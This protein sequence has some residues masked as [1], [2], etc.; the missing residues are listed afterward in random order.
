M[1]VSRGEPSCPNPPVE[2]WRDRR[3]TCPRSTVL[4]KPPAI[5]PDLLYFIRKEAS[6]TL[7]IRSAHSPQFLQLDRG[8]LANA[9]TD[10]ILAD[11]GITTNAYNNGTT[12]QL[13]AFLACEFPS[14][15]ILARIG[16]NRWLPFLMSVPLLRTFAPS[17][18]KSLTIVCCPCAWSRQA[19][20]G[21]R[22]VLAGLHD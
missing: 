14:Q 10:N 12:I 8:N 7:L 11:L 1:M 15:I 20:L 9:L 13:I 19:V 4:G 2:D 22:L 18:R 16:F 17:M 6:L 5:A 3:C 21:R